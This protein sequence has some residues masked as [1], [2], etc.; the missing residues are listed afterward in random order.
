M[1]NDVY[2]KLG[3]NIKKYRN[4]KGLTQQKLADIVD[5]GINFIGKIEVGFSKPSLDIV[6]KIAKALDVKLCDLFDFDNE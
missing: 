5:M 4:K 1:Y 6:I 3:K 2:I